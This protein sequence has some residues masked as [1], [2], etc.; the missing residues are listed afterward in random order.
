MR[1]R[2]ILV[3]VL[4]AASACRSPAKSPSTE[5]ASDASGTAPVTSPAPSLVPAPKNSPPAPLPPEWV[6][7]ASWRNASD[8]AFERALDGW[9][10]AGSARR[11]SPNDL[12]TL[13]LALDGADTAAVRAAVLLARTR[14]PRAGEAL[15]ARLERRVAP[16]PGSSDQDAVDVVAA[17]AFVEGTPA[18]NA[19]ARLAELAAGK[20]PHPDL[21]ARV[22]CARSALALGRDNGIGFLL[23]VLR[24]ATTAGKPLGPEDSATDLAFA[25]TRAAEALAARAGTE[26]RFR[27]EASVKDR[28]A[29]ATRLEKLLPGSPAKKK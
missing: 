3:A 26:S 9:L 27:P 6:L 5:V 20:R 15:L 23:Q 25:Q 17:C 21:C 4:L 29:E 22:E 19:A 13:T 28:E 16:P 7:P 11:L 24:T 8:L 14:D 10:P 2:T 18:T 1:V 12:A